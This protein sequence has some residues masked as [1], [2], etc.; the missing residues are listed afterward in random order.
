MSGALRF[1]HDS[2]RA[3]IVKLRSKDRRALNCFQHAG[4]LRCR[5]SVAA[6]GRCMFRLPFLGSRTHGPRVRPAP[7]KMRPISRCCL[8][9]SRRGRARPCASSSPRRSRS[10]RA[11]SDRARW[12]RRGQIACAA[13][14]AAVFLV[15]RGQVAGRG[16][17]A[18]DA[19]ARPRSGR[20]RH[21]H[22]RHR[23]AH[24][25]AAAAGRSAGKRLADPQFMESRHRKLVLGLDREAVRRTARRRAVVA[26]AA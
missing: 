25:P 12:Q 16:N 9:R 18:R 3:I 2:A 22:A 11:F 13:R 14:R 19:R 5:G 6:D 24:R 17:V 26:G 23:R 15:R 4:L 7:V 20:L 21:D 1:C 8:R 10:G